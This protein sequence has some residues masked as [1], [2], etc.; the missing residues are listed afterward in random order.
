MEIRAEPVQGVAFLPHLLYY[1]AEARKALMTARDSV[2]EA[3]TVLEGRPPKAL[4]L[5]TFPMRAIRVAVI[6][7]SPD[8]MI[9]IRI[10]RL[11]CQPSRLIK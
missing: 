8:S 7:L 3:I 10:Y 9:K 5:L 4:I 1:L 11:D 2:C 6:Y